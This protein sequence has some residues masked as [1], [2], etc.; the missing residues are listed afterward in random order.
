VPYVLLLLRRADE[1]NPISVALWD[2]QPL[3]LLLL[4]AVLC[5]GVHAVLSMLMLL[6]L[7]YAMVLAPTVN[8]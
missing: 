8:A 1:S 2:A 5:R 7:L 6:L 4:L 3:L